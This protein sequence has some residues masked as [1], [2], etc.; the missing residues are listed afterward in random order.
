MDGR[1]IIEDRSDWFETV[2]EENPFEDKASR[3]TPTSPLN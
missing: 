3:D 2:G 1:K